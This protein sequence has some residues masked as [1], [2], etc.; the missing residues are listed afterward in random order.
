MPANR[1]VEI[2]VTFAPFEFQT[3]SVTVQLNISQFNAK[4]I[5]CKFIGISKP[6]L[7]KSVHK[8]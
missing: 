1:E 8:E 7:L 2:T 5:I 4:P 3:A 6:G